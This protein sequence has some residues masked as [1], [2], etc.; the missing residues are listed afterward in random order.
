M[1]TIE[2][3]KSALYQWDINQRIIL[4][5]VEPGMKVY[6]S[7]VGDDKNECLV[8]LTYRENGVVYSNI[9]NILLQQ[10]GIIA[11]YVCVQ[12]E[13]KEYTKHNAEILVLPR[14][15]PIDYIYSEDEIKTFDSLEKRIKCLEEKESENNSSLPTIT[16]EDEGKFLQVIDGK[17]SFSEMPVYDVYEGICSVTPAASEQVLQTANKVLKENIIIESIPYNEVTN[18]AGGITITIL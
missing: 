15:K 16:E 8:L 11:V 7:H 6:Y 17:W 13:N 10:K 1:I 3:N 2:G 14:E 4:T 5:D 12:E 9:P 18:P